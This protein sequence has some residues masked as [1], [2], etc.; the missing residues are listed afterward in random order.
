MKSVC[1][2]QES[3]H[4]HL[5]LYSQASDGPRLVNNIKHLSACLNEMQLKDV[6]KQRNQVEQDVK[7]IIQRIQSIQRQK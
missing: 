6:L 1:S 5:P 3:K 7:R 4:F 2:L